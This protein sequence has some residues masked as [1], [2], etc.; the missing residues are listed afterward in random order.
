[1]PGGDDKKGT[2]ITMLTR[3]FTRTRFL[4][5]AW[6]K[7]SILTLSKIRTSKTLSSALHSAN[8]KQPEVQ[9]WQK[10]GCFEKRQLVNFLNN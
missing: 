10:P 9:M 4:S 5:F 2:H 3:S 6:Q 7:N 1:M 8:N